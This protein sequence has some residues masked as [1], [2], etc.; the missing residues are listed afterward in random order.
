MATISVSNIDVGVCVHSGTYGVAADLTTASGAGILRLTSLSYDA[1]D[2]SYQPDLTGFNNNKSRIE[3]LTRAVS[4]DMSMEMSYNDNWAMILNA[5]CGT[6]TSGVEQ[7]AGQGDYKHTLTLEDESAVNLTMAYLAGDDSSVIEFPTLTV[8]DVTLNFVNGQ[9]ATMDVSALASD[10][11]KD[12]DAVNDETVLAGLTTPSFKAM[13]VGGGNCANH[14]FRAAAHS[15]VTALDSDDDIE[16][17]SATLTI[18]RPYDPYY[19]LRGCDSLRIKQPIQIGLN[20]ATLEIGLGAVDLTEIDSLD[21]WDSFATWMSEL[22]LEGNQIGTGDNETFNL[23][24]PAM[25]P[26]ASA[27]VIGFGSINERI[28]PTIT[29]DLVTAAEVGQAANMVAAGTDSYFSIELTNRTEGNL[30]S[31]TD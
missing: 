9:V 26:G 25:L 4:V 19:V 2:E 5:I 27:P 13:I 20:N 12:A 28:Q 23:K 22:N 16:I 3:K 31:A 15:T 24:C 6:A 7:T 21:V 14:Y 10:I 29:F 8:T 17:T 30:G 1:T 18:S 11:K